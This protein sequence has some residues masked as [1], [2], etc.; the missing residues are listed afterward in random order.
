ME[1]LIQVVQKLRQEYRFNG[2]IHLKAIPGAD[3]RLIEAAG[4]LVDRMSVNIELPTQQGLK[5]LAPQKTKAAILGPMGLIRDSILDHKA[6]PGIVK[7]S[8]SFVP[9]GQTTQLMVGA[10]PDHD[11]GILNLAEGLYRHYSL[12]RVYYSAYIPVVSHV[13]LPAL[14]GPPLLREH[15][16]YQADWLLRF[17]GFAAKE[18]LDERNPD[19]EADLDPKCSWALRHLENFPVEINR[20]DY[21][22]LLRVPGI[23]PTSAQK[24][25]SARR[26]HSLDFDT[27]KKI[28]VVIKRAKYFV[29]CRGKFFGGP[30]LDED[31]IRQILA[32][33]GEGFLPGR[34]S[35]QQTAL[36]T[37]PPPALL[38]WQHQSS[39][40]LG[41]A[42]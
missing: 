31:Q 20:A 3:P 19:F 25:V 12:K 14:T 7:R 1:L 13:N 42:R 37:A 36:F 30:V 8:P 17:Y 24:I 33:Q 40:L 41:E 22:T 23:G 21:G 10:T 29:T 34:A 2:Y 26:V 35:W 5:L 16:L 32:P 18:L 27:L 15:R 39:L 38:D 9:A 6:A 28:G 11:L 4:R